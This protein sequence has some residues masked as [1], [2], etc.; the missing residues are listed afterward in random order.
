MSVCSFIYYALSFACGVSL[1]DVRAAKV[2]PVYEAEAGNNKTSQDTQ[3][4]KTDSRQFPKNSVS[5][6]P[7]LEYSVRQNS[8]LFKDGSSFYFQSGSRSLTKRGISQDHLKKAVVVFF[9]DWCPHCDS[10]LRA[11]SP[12]VELL[13]LSGVSTIFVAIPSIERLKNWKDPNIDEFNAAENKIA[14]Y[15]IKLATKKTF[16]AMIG[17]RSVLATCGIEGLPVFVA[18]KEGKEVCR[19]VGEKAV[20]KINISDPAVLKQFLSIWD[21]EESRK[22]ESVE[23]K[24]DGDQSIIGSQDAAVGKISYDEKD[25]ENPKKRDSDIKKKHKKRV[26]GSCTRV[27]SVNKYIEKKQVNWKKARDFTEE[28]NRFDRTKV[29]QPGLIFYD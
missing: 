17:D 13:R 2:P 20:Q 14:S 8:Q 9:G 6:N 23:V 16:V 25:P 5:S 11:F 3:G 4:L 21:S 10:F 12:H 15:D 22:V 19:F 27:S 24:S 26:S 7:F 1:S 28:L 18:V 29:R